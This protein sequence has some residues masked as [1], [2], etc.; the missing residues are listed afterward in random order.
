M[1][2]SELLYNAALSPLN[3]EFLLKDYNAANYRED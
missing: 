1:Y 2:G 3:A